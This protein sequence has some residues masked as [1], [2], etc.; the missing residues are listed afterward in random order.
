MC[1]QL[2]WIVQELHLSEKL[3]TTTS[4]CIRSAAGGVL[5]RSHHQP[6]FRG[7]GVGKVS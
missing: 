6:R 1:V 5:R 4:P 7:M 2:I 3:V